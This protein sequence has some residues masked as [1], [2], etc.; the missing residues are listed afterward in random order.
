MD[1]LIKIKRLVLLFVT[2]FLLLSCDDNDNSATDTSIA[3]IASKNS[4]LS[5]LVAALTKTGLTTTLSEPGS[6]TVFAPTNTAFNTFLSENGYANLDA[7]PVNALKEILLNHVISGSFQSSALTTGYV[8][9]LAKGSAS[10]TNTLSMF[11]NTSSGV[12]INGIATVSS[13]NILA[14]NGVIHVVDKVIGLPTIVTHATANPNFSSL[15]NA[16]TAEGQPNFVNILSGN[17]SF[18]VFAPTNAAFTSLD[19]ELAPGGVAGV[20][21]ENLTKVLQYHVVNGAN[22]TSSSLTNGQV[23]NTLVNQSFTVNLTPARITDVNARVSN[24]TAVDVQ[25]SNGIIHVLDKVLLP[26]FE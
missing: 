18:T 16:L 17:G 10:S 12:K 20:S 11:I 25:C 8:K 7:V 24:I 21:S 9:T 2:P 1:N 4:E 3:G 26:S 14:N 15:V 22:V 6:F 13:A 5:S 19:S 23:V